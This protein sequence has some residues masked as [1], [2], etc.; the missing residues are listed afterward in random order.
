M[1]VRDVMTVD[2]KTL[3][4][5]DALSIAEELMEMERVRHLPVI[6]GMTGTLAGIVSQRDLYLNALVRALGFGQH[7]KEMT[8]SRLKVK[9]C[10]REDPVTIEP[11]AEVAAAAS[12]MVEHRI[13]CLPV[14]EG[15]KLVGIVTETDLVRTLVDG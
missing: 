9:E 8:L 6:D 11:G 12:L 15:G 4:R 14:I 3:E 5:N 7:A 10:M 2:P 1:L 13:G